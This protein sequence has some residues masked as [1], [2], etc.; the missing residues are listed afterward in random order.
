VAFYR[1]GSPQVTPQNAAVAVNV[2]CLRC[3]TIARAI[4]YVIPVD[5]FGQVP[6][7]ARQ[8]V[9]EFDRELRE[10]DRIHS[11]QDAEPAAVEAELNSILARF[12]SLGAYLLD[13]RDEA[14][15]TDTPATPLPEDTA[16]PAATSAAPPEATTTVEPSTTATATAVP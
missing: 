16:T 5:D 2:Q 13:A 9:R 14:R 12:R 1:A 10:F 11:R 4:Q 15:D 3:I 8:L 7:D 6:D